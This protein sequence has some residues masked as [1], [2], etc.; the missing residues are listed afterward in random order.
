MAKLHFPTP[1]H[2]VQIRVLL[3]PIM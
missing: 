2:N 1:M 3:Q